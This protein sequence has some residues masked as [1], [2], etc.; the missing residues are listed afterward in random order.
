MSLLREWSDGCLCFWE[1]NMPNTR[2]ATVVSRNKLSTNESTRQQLWNSGTGELLWTCQEEFDD[3]S[4]ERLKIFGPKFSPSGDHAAFFHGRMTVSI[5]DTT[6][7]TP[8]EVLK[9]DLDAI[10]P[11]KFGLFRTFALGPQPNS[12]ALVYL[13]NN[14]NT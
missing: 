14:V 11:T 7:N 5:V 3:S 4:L 8:T 10:L 6:S 2:I 13:G 9:I 12:L 1:V